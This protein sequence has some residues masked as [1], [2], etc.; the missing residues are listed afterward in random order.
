MKPLRLELSRT[1]GFDLH[2]KSRALN[3]LDVVNVARGPGRKWGNPFKI[4]DPIIDAKNGA[5]RMT[6]EQCV[7]LYGQMAG[8]ISTPA[9]E[10]YLAELFGG[11]QPPDRATAVQELR[12]KN[13]ACWCHLCERHAETG[14]PLDEDCADCEPCHVDPLGRIA[15]P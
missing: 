5:G 4:G 7:M 14:K 8:R 3:G 9:E 6:R 12:G 11:K 13:L 1:K 2:A 15:N 10:A